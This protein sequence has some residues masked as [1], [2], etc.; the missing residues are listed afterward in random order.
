[1]EP[2]YSTEKDEK[3]K[4][5]LKKNKNIKSM[6]TKNTPLTTH[7]QVLM[8]TNKFENHSEALF[9]LVNF[10]LKQR[11]KMKTIL[12]YTGAFTAFQKQSLSTLHNL[13]ACHMTTHAGTTLDMYG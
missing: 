8:K 10:R 3:R 7:F 11:F 5:N 2:K 12:V 9:T 1:M 4:K 13:K 6:Q